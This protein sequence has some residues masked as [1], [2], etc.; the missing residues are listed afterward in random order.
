MKKERTCFGKNQKWRN[1]KTLLGRKFAEKNSRLNSFM[2][3][4][5]DGIG[6]LICNL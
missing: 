5:E 4:T 6:F 1:K 3:G 2:F